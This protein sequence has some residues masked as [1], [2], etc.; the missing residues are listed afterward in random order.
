MIV[1]D[2]QQL[3]WCDNLQNYHHL[4]IKRCKNCGVLS[5]HVAPT[6]IFEHSVLILCEPPTKY[7]RK[8][9]EQMNQQYRVMPHNM[10]K[11]PL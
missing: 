5:E 7:H 4:R 1:H 3:D 6:A 8:N 9:L 2:N 11:L 10:A